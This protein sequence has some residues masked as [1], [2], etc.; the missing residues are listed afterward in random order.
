MNSYSSFNT[1]KGKSS[2]FVHFVFKNSNTAM[3]NLRKIERILDGGLRARSSE[4]SLFSTRTQNITYI[5]G[6]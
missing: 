3:L 4:C 2:R 5:N 1:S 6:K